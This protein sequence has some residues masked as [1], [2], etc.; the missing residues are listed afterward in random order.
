[1]NQIGLRRRSFIIG[2]GVVAATAAVHAQPARSKAPR[3]LTIAQIMDTSQEQLDVSKDFVIGS[4]AAWQEINARGGVRGR[5]VSH[6]NIEVDGSADSL[7]AALETVRK[8]P[9]CVV[10]SGTAGNRTATSLV[11]LLQEAD[12]PIAHAAP[13]LQNSTIAID[14]NTFPIFAGCQEQIVHAL[15][16]LA[17]VGFSDL[18]AVYAKNEEWQLYKDEVDHTAAGL[19]L[20]LLN[21]RG[22]GELTRLGAGLAASTPPVLLFVGGTPELLA[23]IQGLEKQQRM[24][25]VI[26]MSDVN[27]QAVAQLGNLRSTPVI[28]THPVP[29]VTSAMPIVRAFRETLARLFD[30]TPTPLSL[31]GFIA[32]RYTYDVL[33][34]VEVPTRAAVLAAFQRRTAYDLGGYRVAFDNHGR[35]AN[36]VTQSMLTLDGRILS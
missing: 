5:S 23:F 14:D 16:S 12:L 35:S 3:T 13:W 2:S 18:A 15:K 19:K 17:T 36:F 28:T 21:I 25:Y 33:A 8:N 9:D 34:G 22:D 24:R 7:R 32:A 30:E 31:A 27:L 10:L 20:K 6:L 1:M 26:A 11:G 4:R 29:E